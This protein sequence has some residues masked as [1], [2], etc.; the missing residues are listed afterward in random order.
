MSMRDQEEYSDTPGGPD[1]AEHP[2]K[3]D[4][5][6]SEAKFAIGRLVYCFDSNGIYGCI[7]KTCYGKS[8][9]N[10]TERS[11]VHLNLISI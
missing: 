2:P 11:C 3:P 6:S 7:K 8:N 5:F 9:E 10:I 4:W 1:N